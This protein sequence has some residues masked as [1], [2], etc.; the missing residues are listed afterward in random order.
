MALTLD[1]VTDRLRARA[2]EAEGLGKTAKLDFGADGVVHLDARQTPPAV[3]NE[4][5]PADATLRLTLDD[6]RDIV[7]GELDPLRA[8][9]TR[10]LK[11]KG[12]KGLALK[13]AAL[14]RAGHG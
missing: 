10:R 1:K 7:R 13:L 8:L 6:L 5:L 14:F 12:D 11:L 3:S 2:G 4:D 9:F